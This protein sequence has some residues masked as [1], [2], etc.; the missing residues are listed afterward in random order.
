MLKIGDKIRRIKGV[1]H[2]E[3]NMFKGNIYT[4]KSMNDDKIQ[5]IEAPE[6]WHSNFF[7]FIERGTQL[8]FNF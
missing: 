8:E 7:E 5:L 3:Y 1:D 6:N 4:I 2:S